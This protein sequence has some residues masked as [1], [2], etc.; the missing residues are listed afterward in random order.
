[1]KKEIG[2]SEDGE[3]TFKTY[4]RYFENADDTSKADIGSFLT[5]TQT[6]A[7]E[8]DNNG[9]QVFFFSLLSKCR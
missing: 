1:M 6:T 9:D 8:R 3:I 5:S 4:W 7:E 2:L